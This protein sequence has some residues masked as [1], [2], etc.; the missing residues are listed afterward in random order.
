MNA[1]KALA[2][3]AHAPRAPPPVNLTHAETL[4]K[5]DVVVADEAHMHNLVGGAVVVPAGT[6]LHVLPSHTG[7]LF[8]LQGPTVIKLPPVSD[9]AVPLTYEFVL[10]RDTSKEGTEESE[11]ESEDEKEDEKEEEDALGTEDKE[12]DDNERDDKEGDEK[13]DDVQFVCAPDHEFAPSSAVICHDVV[14]LPHLAFS[15][16]DSAPSDSASSDSASSDLEHAQT[17]R[18]V[19]P[20]CV[21]WFMLKV[22]TTRIPADGRVQ[23]RIT[24]NAGIAGIT[25]IT[26]TATIAG[27]A[28]GT[29]PRSQLLSKHRRAQF[30]GPAL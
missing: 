28:G 21:K 13:D 3:R 19:F 11:D 22:Q 29:A 25:G 17:V 27:T 8:V 5:G 24:G 15:K 20:A 26:E 18:L 30:C 23:L 1:S 16:S 14:V 6:E 12:R 10:N 7:T 9:P 4:F 2:P